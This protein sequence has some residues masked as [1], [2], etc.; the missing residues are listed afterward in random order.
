MI[1][2]GRDEIKC[3]NC[4]HGSI[5][6]YQPIRSK[7]PE[8]NHQPSLA[9]VSM[10]ER[11]DA[12]FYYDLARFTIQ[13]VRDLSNRASWPKIMN[14]PICGAKAD[15][16]QRKQRSSIDLRS[17]MALEGFQGLYGRFVVHTDHEHDS[18][19]LKYDYQEVLLKVSKVQLWNFQPKRNLLLGEWVPE[20]PTGRFMFTGAILA[21]KKPLLNVVTIQVG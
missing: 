1:T 7:S 3:L 18:M 9:N 15:W 4:T 8:Y 11:V 17:E 12:F 21:N 19:G 13:T 20:P 10:A 5:T 2:K 6:L 14:F 16:Y